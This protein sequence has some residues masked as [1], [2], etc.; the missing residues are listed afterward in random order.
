MRSLGQVPAPTLL[1]GYSALQTAIVAFESNALTRA[2]VRAS[3]GIPANVIVKAFETARTKASSAQPREMS[4]TD[5]FAMLLG[6]LTQAR[7]DLVRAK[8][9]MYSTA[10]GNT[11]ARGKFEQ[12]LA[13]DLQ[14]L[15]QVSN[16]LSRMVA[17]GAMPTLTRLIGGTSGLGFIT[18]A[19]SALRLVWSAI[20]TW[21]AIQV[22]RE[23]YLREQ[24]ALCEELTRRGT[25]CTPQ[26]VAELQAELQQLTDTPAAR[27]LDS[28]GEGIRNVT[29][30][31]DNVGQGIGKGLK[32]GITTLSVG[33]GLVALWWA[34]PLISSTRRKRREAE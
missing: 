31:F 9:F 19:I 34:W 11:A 10:S 28:V 8:L 26:R 14:M 17:E 29:S 20:Q 25:P 3:S 2:V 4:E 6:T 7:T 27:F 13:A 30:P 15:Q 21:Q 12:I 32:I 24:I 33:V 1:T 23:R 18:I 16:I 22:R 5:V